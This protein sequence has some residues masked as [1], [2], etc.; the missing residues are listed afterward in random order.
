M[1]EIFTFIILIII[2]FI[3]AIPVTN[4]SITIITTINPGNF[5]NSAAIQFNLLYPFVDKII[6][7]T[8]YEN[9]IFNIS[10]LENSYK[11]KFIITNKISISTIINLANRD[12]IYVIANSNI[13]FDYTSINFNMLYHPDFQDIWFFISSQCNDF[14]GD[15]DAVAFIPPVKN[16]NFDITLNI[17]N[18]AKKFSYIMAI[19]Q[20]QFNPCHFI[21]LSRLNNLNK[22]I[23]P[24]NIYS[25]AKVCEPSRVFSAEFVCKM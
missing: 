18:L 20:N 12:N 2:N 8:D 23:K 10:K 13:V 4:L 9:I 3:S 5:D 1:F 24:K 15:I 19:N 25:W 17:K 11:I 22:Q 16:I 7:I 21:K 6:I 14:D